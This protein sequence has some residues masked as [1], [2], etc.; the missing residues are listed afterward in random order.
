MD[1]MP[2]LDRIPAPPMD[3]FNYA[4]RELGESTMHLVI[5]FDGHLDEERLE[6]ACAAIR[7]MVPV[8]GSR[9]VEAPAPYWEWIPGGNAHDRV[10]VHPSLHRD[11][12]LQ[13]VLTLPLDPAT[14]PPVRLDILRSGTG[15]TLCI[16]VHHAAMDAYGLIVY[17]QLLAGCYRHPDTGQG[18]FPFPCP[19]RSLTGVLSQFTGEK[20]VPVLISHGSLHPGWTFPARPGDC[21]KRAFAIRTL[22]AERI[23]AIKSAARV[24]GAT[25]ND[26]LLAA[27]FSALCDYSH[28]E[29][30]TEVPISVSIDLRRYLGGKKSAPVEMDPDTNDAMAS[31]PLDAIANLSV[32]FNVLLCTGSR[33]FDEQI[34]QATAAMQVHKAHNPGIDAAVDIESFGYANFAGICERVR[35]MRDRAA[36]TGAATPLL[37]NIGILPEASTAFSPALPVTNAFIAGIIINPPGIAL[38]VT[39]FRNCMTLSIGYGSAT[40]LHDIM[41]RFMDTLTGYLPKG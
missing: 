26:L 3:Q 34:V 2:T 39:T 30:V 8:L 27:F 20:P 33:T 22:P 37:G 41:E 40:I 19:D 35:M 31:L 9:F 21:K 36:E 32:A 24:R 14:G 1:P 17:S 16:T 38:G 6:Q 28:P 5:V 23:Y 11:R 15:D 13:N 7:A 29:P 25:V 18:R 10:L 4:L 12:D